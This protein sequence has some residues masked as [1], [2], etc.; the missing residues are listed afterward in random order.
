MQNKDHLTEVKARR[1]VRYQFG[2]LAEVVHLESGWGLTGPATVLSVCGC[3]VRT[4][5]RF[6]P[7]SMIRLR[8][9][10]GDVTVA[11]SGYVVH[12]TDAGMGIAFNAIGPIEQSTLEKLLVGATPC[13]TL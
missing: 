9:T 1:A 11:T 6:S 4:K 5:T 3:F 13:P 7:G 10:Q 8:I 2:G 12:N